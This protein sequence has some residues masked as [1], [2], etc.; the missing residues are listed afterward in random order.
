MQMSLKIT[1][2]LMAV[3]LPSTT[4]VTKFTFLFSSLFFDISPLTQKLTHNSGPLPPS[5]P[6]LQ[7]AA[8]KAAAQQQRRQRRHGNAGDHTA[9]AARQQGGGGGDSAAAAVA[10]ILRQWRWRG[11]GISAVMALAQRQH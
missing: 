5:P 9:A 11:C 2:L 6:S 10:G 4:I 1:P 7:V 8:A 3:H